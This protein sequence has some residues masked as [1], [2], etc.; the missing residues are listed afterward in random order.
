M[1]CK[2]VMMMKAM[3]A[4][5]PWVAIMASDLGSQLNPPSMSA[6]IAGSPSSPGSE[7]PA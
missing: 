1:M 2:M 4:A 6:A 7:T 5:T 3:V